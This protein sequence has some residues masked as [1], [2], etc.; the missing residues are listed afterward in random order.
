MG[1]GLANWGFI[2]GGLLLGGTLQAERGQ[3]GEGLCGVENIC[4][5]L[6]EDMG[7]QIGAYGDHTVPTPAMDRMAAEGVVMTNAYVTQATCSPS[8]GSLYSGLY[9]HQSGQM[10]LS[11]NFGY[12]LHRGTPAYPAQ[13]RDAGYGTALNYKI[14]V[15]PEWSIGFDRQIWQKEYAEWG[16]DDRDTRYMKRVMEAFFEEVIDAGQPFYLQPQTGETHRPFIKKDPGVNTKVLDFEGSPYRIMTAG[17]VALL[18]YFGPDMPEE[19]GLKEDLA[20]YYN[21]I[22]RFDRAVGMVLE[23]LEKRGLLDKT[24]VIVTADHGPTYGRGKLNLYELGMHVPMIIRWPGLTNPGTRSEALVSFIDLMPTFL[25]VAGLPVPDY[26]P[27]RSLRDLFEGKPWRTHLYGEYTAHTSV[28]DYWPSRMVRDG[29][30]KLIWNMLGGQA[31]GGMTPEGCPDINVSQRAPEQSVT[32]TVYRRFRYPPVYELYDLEKDPYE[33]DNLAQKQ[34]FTS[35]V[36]GLR[37]RIENWMD[38]TV[39]PFVDPEYLGAFTR[40]YR[41]REAQ[42]IAYEQE[43]GFDSY[44][45]KP[46]TRFDYEPWLK[47]FENLEEAFAS[48]RAAGSPESF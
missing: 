48:A 11:N 47:D 40:A 4:L 1:R 41:E 3:A 37:Q 42:V 28:R 12:R 34:E 43:H 17:E 15:G 21:A 6:A 31:P 16:F 2:L 26:L 38:D 35:I 22:Q 33:L 23:D 19:R 13:L 45:G 24:L 46:V 7:L 9:P 44:W 36:D 8:R 30:Y 14:H 32:D 29:R 27:G 10:G 39:D 25:E 18:R 20:Q 5:I